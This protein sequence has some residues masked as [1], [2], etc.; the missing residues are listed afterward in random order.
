MIAA[1][2][3]RKRVSQLRSSH[4]HWHL[5]EVFV[6]I[7]GVQR[8]LWRAVDR[9][10]EVLEAFVSKTGDREAALI[11]LRKLV[12]R[13]GG[14]EELVTD[15]LRSCGAALMELRIQGK[16]VTDRWANS[17]AENSHQPF[18]RRERACCGSSACSHSN[19]RHQSTDH[20]TTTSAQTG[21][22]PVK[23]SRCGPAP[24]LSASRGRSAPANGR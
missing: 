12:K 3:R 21:A 8:Y 24:S 19:R 23:T 11:F 5:K 6:R 4:W 14:P 17:R 20:C 10:G 13:N 16:C 7:D 22:S 18:R 9:E 2:L 1:E 15:K